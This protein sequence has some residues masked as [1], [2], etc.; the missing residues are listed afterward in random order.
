MII[1][2][3][4]VFYVLSADNIDETRVASYLIKPVYSSIYKVHT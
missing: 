2:F 4:Y 1:S 3:D